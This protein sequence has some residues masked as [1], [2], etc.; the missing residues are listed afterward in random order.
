MSRC[1]IFEPI[2]SQNWRR[3]HRALRYDN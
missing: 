2:D 3:L 1:D